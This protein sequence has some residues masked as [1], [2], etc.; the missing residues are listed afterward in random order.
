MIAPQFHIQKW[1]HSSVKTLEKFQ[2]SHPLFPVRSK[3]QKP[4]SRWLTNEA[5]QEI[6]N[7]ENIV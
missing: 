1:C 5:E 4:F 3:H 2:S 6:N 7:G